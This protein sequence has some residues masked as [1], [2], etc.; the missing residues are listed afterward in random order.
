MSS[1]CALAAGF[2]LFFARQLREKPKLR[3]RVSYFLPYIN[4]KKHMAEEKISKRRFFRFGLF[5]T[6][7]FLYAALCRIDEFGIFSDQLFKQ[8]AKLQIC[9][10][11]RRI[12]SRCRTARDSRFCRRS[13][14]R[15]ALKRNFGQKFCRR[16]ASHRRRCR[17][18]DSCEL[19]APTPT[20]T[21]AKWS[22]F[23]RRKLSLQDAESEQI[24]LVGG[25]NATSAAKATAAATAAASR[26]R[27][28]TKPATAAFV[29]GDWFFWSRAYVL[30]DAAVEFCRAS[31][32]KKQ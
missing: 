32:V 16:Q 9:R 2:L 24:A 5:S 12:T 22:S 10:Y 30:D 23:H 17:G 21:S 29:N 4:T 26:R 13:H 18:S 14:G 27:Q 11:E 25:E 3:A 28:R 20:T 6:P 7:H 15:R 8:M 19:S 31:R 1:S